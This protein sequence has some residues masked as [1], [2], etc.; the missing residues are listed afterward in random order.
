MIPLRSYHLDNEGNDMYHS[1]LTLVQK[2]SV[3]LIYIYKKL[4]Y[5]NQLYRQEID[6]YKAS[7]CVDGIIDSYQK[8]FEFINEHSRLLKN[9]FDKVPFKPPNLLNIVI[10]VKN[11]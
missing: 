8:K 7:R 9:K 10:Y 5:E 6:D 4:K 11:H 3:Y 1:Y 2:E